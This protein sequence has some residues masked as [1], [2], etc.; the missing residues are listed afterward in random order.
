MTSIEKSFIIKSKLTTQ[1]RSYI[2]VV[3]KCML[4]VFRPL[5]E[6]V[7]EGR[8]LKND[9]SFLV[10]FRVSGIKLSF[11]KPH[12]FPFQEI[13]PEATRINLETSG[14]LKGMSSVYSVQVNV[15]GI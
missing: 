2:L 1:I 4:R 5:F 10:P 6:V 12:P 15:N 7:R 11:V 8:I 14:E 9:F 13:V 3:S